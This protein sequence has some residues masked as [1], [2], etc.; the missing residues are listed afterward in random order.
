M[1]LPLLAFWSK[2]L[3]YRLQRYFSTKPVA[4]SI[5]LVCA[6]SFQTKKTRHTG[7]YK[8]RKNNINLLQEQAIRENIPTLS[9]FKYGNIAD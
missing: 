9:E 6:Y 4:R 2:H 8:N 1:H 3:Y 7:Y 5:L